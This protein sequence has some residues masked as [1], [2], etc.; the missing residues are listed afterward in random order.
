[1]RYC[2]Q[3]HKITTGEPLFCNFCGRSYD[4][5][6]CPSRHP[7][8]RNAE[9]CSACGSRELSTP[10]PHV[11]L[12][13]TICLRLLAVFPGLLLLAVSVLFL[14]GLVHALLTSPQLQAQFFAVGLMLALLWYLYM[15]LPHFL[16]HLLIR[17]FRRS[18]DTR[19]DGHGH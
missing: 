17:L 18:K 10:Q 7:N 8:P 13:L 1:M 14:F 11:P 4:Y 15:H 3:C 5:K 6:L 2:N 9:I 16:R 12:W 19:G